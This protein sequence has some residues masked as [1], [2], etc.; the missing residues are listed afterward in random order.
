MKSE[1]GQHAVRHDNRPSEWPSLHFFAPNLFASSSIREKTSQTNLA[2]S[3]CGVA[4][5]KKTGNKMKW[6]AIPSTR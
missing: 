1:E 6:K 2:P 4:A 5:A 3:G